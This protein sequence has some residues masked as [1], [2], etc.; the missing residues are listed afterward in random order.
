MVNGL[1]ELPL[2]RAIR[3]AH[4]D[5]SCVR[6]FRRGPVPRSVAP[7]IDGLVYLKGE[8]ERGSFAQAEITDAH[9]YDL[10]GTILE[11]EPYCAP[12]LIDV[13]PSGSAE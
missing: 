13:E 8:G 6:A 12:G 9:G 5:A 2:F 4:P 11:L 10:Y 3:P 7:E 1:L